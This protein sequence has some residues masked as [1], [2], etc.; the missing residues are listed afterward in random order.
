MVV[1][2]ARMLRIA[3]VDAGQI[4]SESFTAFRAFRARVKALSD[5]FWAFEANFSL[6]ACS[7]RTRSLVNGPCMASIIS[8]IVIFLGDL[9]REDPP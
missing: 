5:V 8:S 2:L 1:C 4:K 9:A 6:G 3:N 7:E